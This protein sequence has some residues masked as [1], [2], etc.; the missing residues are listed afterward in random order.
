MRARDLEIIRVAVGSWCI[1]DARREE[2]DPARVLGFVTETARG[3][4]VLALTPAPR[5]CGVFERWGAAIAGLCDTLTAEPT[6]STRG[7]T[8]NTSV[9]EAGHDPATSRL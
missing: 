3:F 2:D 8:E 7:T 1:G 6:A 5:D 4:E 9:A